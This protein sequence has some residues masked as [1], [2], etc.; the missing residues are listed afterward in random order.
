MK[1]TD[2]FPP[3]KSWLELGGYAVYTEVQPRRGTLRR[4]DILGIHG[5]VETVVEL[6]TSLSLTLLDQCSHWKNHAHLVYAAVPAPSRYKPGEL[7]KNYVSKLGL[8]IINMYGIG[9]LYVTEDKVYNVIRARLNRKIKPILSESLT[10]YHLTHSPDAGTNKGGHVTAYRTTM[11]RVR[12]FLERMHDRHDSERANLQIKEGWVS[13][14]VLLE[15]CSTHYSTP[16]NGLAAALINNE[17]DW[18]EC[19]V[20]DRQRHY[21][22]KPELLITTDENNHTT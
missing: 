18:C 9:L 6:K 16:K 1:E 21:R 14:P 7:I 3:V 15:K 20:I 13:L 10:Q 19:M 22:L 2:L 5:C 12:E 8:E 17:S 11:L 4:A